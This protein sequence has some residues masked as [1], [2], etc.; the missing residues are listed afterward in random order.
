MSH[1]IFTENRNWVLG[2][3]GKTGEKLSARSFTQSSD[4]DYFQ[5]N[6][7]SKKLRKS[8]FVFHKEDLEVLLKS[9]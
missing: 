3:A 6:F 4:P 7:G 9:L 8:D 2:T 5:L 1:V